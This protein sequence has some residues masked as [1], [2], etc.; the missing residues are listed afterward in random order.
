MASGP[1]GNNQSHRHPGLGNDSPMVNTCQPDGYLMLNG[2]IWPPTAP[3]ECEDI[4][5]ALADPPHP[6]K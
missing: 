1:C 2:R 4:S 3:S 5:N 6:Q